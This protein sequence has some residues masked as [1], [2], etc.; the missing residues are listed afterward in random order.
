MSTGTMTS[1][2]QITVP[3]DV[4]EALRLTPGTKVTFTRNTDG[5]AASGFLVSHSGAR[6]PGWAGAVLAL[7]LACAI[8]F[9]LRA[10]AVA[11]R[12]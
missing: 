10:Q 3:K 1:N 11:E 8:A 4:R 12:E 2:W 6:A 9:A 5:A 7:A